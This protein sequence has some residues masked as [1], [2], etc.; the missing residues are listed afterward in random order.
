MTGE[1]AEADAEV[2][3]AQLSAEDQATA[4][5]VFRLLFVGFFE[6]RNHEHRHVGR[7]FLGDL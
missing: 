1:D 2:A 6:A 5:A 3:L 4:D 7:T